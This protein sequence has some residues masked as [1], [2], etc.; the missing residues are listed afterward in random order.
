ME[1]ELAARVWPG[2]KLLGIQPAWGGRE[3]KPQQGSGNGGENY[4]Q[5]Y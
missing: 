3:T 2:T 5:L 4:P 1:A